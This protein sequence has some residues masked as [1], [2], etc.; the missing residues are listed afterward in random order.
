[1]FSG[2]FDHKLTET[3][4]GSLKQYVYGGLWKQ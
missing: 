4:E 1:M 3:E 2:I